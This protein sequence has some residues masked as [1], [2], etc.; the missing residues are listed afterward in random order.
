MLDSFLAVFQE[1]WIG[2][3]QVVFSCFFHPLFGPYKHNYNDAPRF[4]CQMQ[5]QSWTA[6][7]VMLLSPVINQNDQ[8]H[9][10]GTRWGLGQ[11]LDSRITTQHI[12]CA[13]R[14]IARTTGNGDNVQISGLGT[15]GVP[16]CYAPPSSQKTSQLSRDTFQKQNS[17]NLHVC[18]FVKTAQDSCCNKL[19][20]SRANGW[21][22]QQGE[23]H[24]RHHEWLWRQCPRQ[25]LQ[26]F[27][28]GSLSLEG[29]P[30]LVRV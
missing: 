19:N 2:S 25:E 24:P 1:L 7:D 20:E 18:W 22:D 4:L 16:S 12:S 29:S 3:E 6:D 30:S 26:S 21:L 14:R 23:F 13:E 11:Q 15:R 8:R 10:L 5:P 27:S 28:V 17:R 9:C